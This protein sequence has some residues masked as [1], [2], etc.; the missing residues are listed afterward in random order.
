MASQEPSLDAA[1]A[2]A[3]FDE[4]GT[5]ILNHGGSGQSLWVGPAGAADHASRYGLNLAAMDL[6]VDGATRRFGAAG[7]SR[8]DVDA[9]FVA[10][11]AGDADRDSVDRWAAQWVTAEAPNVEDPVVWWALTLLWGI[12]ARP[13]RGGPCL[14]DDHQVAGWLRELRARAAA[15]PVT[16]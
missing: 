8:A 12:D 4:S 7:P 16:P 9:R 10:L 13:G 14:H 1:D 11:L 3:L 5:A 15:D 2:G 6:R